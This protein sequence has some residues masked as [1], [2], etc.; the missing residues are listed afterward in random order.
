LSKLP[1][2]D[3]LDERTENPSWIS[4]NGARNR[5]ELDDI[6][7]PLASLVLGNE[8]LRAFEALCDIRLGQAGFQPHL[9]H[10]A[11]EC[12]LFSAMD[13]FDRASSRHAAEIVIL[14]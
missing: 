5:H 9:P 8:R 11:A 13:G 7:P 6:E 1:L 12:A 4:A 3:G 2:A 10:D 14:I